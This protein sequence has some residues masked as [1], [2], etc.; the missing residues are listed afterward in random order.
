MTE[1]VIILGGGVA[2]LSAAHELVERGFD[3]TIY[4]AK[5]ILGGKARSV[6]V[7]GTGML[8][9]KD[10]PGEHGFRFFPHFYKHVIDTMKRIPHEDETVYDHLVSATEMGIARFDQP[11]VPF[12]LGFPKSFFHLKR[13]LNSLLKTNWGLTDAE[14]DLFIDKIWQI[15]TSCLERRNVEYEGMSWWEFLEAEEQSE[16]FRRVFAG[17]TRSLVAANAKEASMKTIGNVLSQLLLDFISPLT[18][19][20]RLLNG[21]T[22]DVW[23]GPWLR[24]LQGRG[25]KIVQNAQC[26]KIQCEGGR[27]GNVLI[28]QDGGVS[29]VKGDYYLSALPVE[30]MEKLLTD[31]MIQIDPSLK[32]IRKLK[33]SLNWMNGIQFFLREDIP[34]LHGHILCQDTP[35]ALTM[36]SQS[37]F[38]PAD[39]TN[40]GDG[41]VKG[42]LSVCISDWNT[43]GII[44]RK[45][46]SECTRDEIKEEV[47][48]QL[49]RSLNA[50]ESILNDDVL[51]SW[52]LDPDLLF[53]KSGITN[54]S[55]LLINEV[56]TWRLRPEATTEIS[57]LFLASD[58]V[59]TNTDLASMEAANEAARRAVNGILSVSRSEEPKCD[60][61]EMYEFELF[62]P[63]HLVD[64]KRYR[65]NLPWDGKYSMLRRMLKMIQLL[66]RQTAYNRKIKATHVQ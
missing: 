23:I 53:G 25:V 16:D 40:Y 57:N 2:G 45:K 59:R 15:M 56:D 44:Y 20:D 21:P 63:W 28:L 61:W 6:P 35:W 54:G 18:D 33:E 9:R 17:V 47:W 43:P 19:P 64:S 50:E 27:I 38:W 24:Y 13:N 58:Y 34:I 37:Q 62:T 30:G 31:E 4:E 29:T 46:A 32:G 10:L 55:P 41:N 39:I 60:I 48:A 26:I 8:G 12:S 14:R 51:H 11:V 49:K 5:P 22:N 52:F 66:M 42:I 1:K 36:I 7:F 3:V 65:R